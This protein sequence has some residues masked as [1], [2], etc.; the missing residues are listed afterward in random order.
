VEEETPIS[1]LQ[2]TL[3]ASGSAIVVNARRE[4]VQI[5]TKIDLVEW[6]SRRASAEGSGRGA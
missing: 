1:A 6:I 2:E 3:L 4:P 5:L